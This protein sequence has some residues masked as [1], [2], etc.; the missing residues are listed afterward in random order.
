MKKHTIGAALAVLT[1][2]SAVGALANEAAAA[3]VPLLSRDAEIEMAL[4]AAPEH[5]RAEAGV[6]VL[7][8]Q[9]Y[10]QIRPSRNNFTCL[11]NR[12]HPMALKPT[13]WDAEGTST[14]VPKVLRFGELLMQG[15]PLE[16][17][18]KEID[19]G[20]K[21]GRF[22]SPSRPG[23]AY[24][25]SGDIRNVDPRTGQTWTFPP[26]VMIYAPNLTNADIGIT[27]EALA[28]NPDLPFVA[29]AGPHGYLIV[30]VTKTEHH[31]G[32]R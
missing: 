13:C 10:L 29:Y 6:Y 28:K 1:S 14:I 18:N 2:A 24:M 17:I 22:R 30:S 15:V 8:K 3:Q 32:G 26:H 11:V 25:L 16:A 7:E 4:S 20:F 31:G 27:G 23:I 19:E 5:L 21:S 12:D 9:G